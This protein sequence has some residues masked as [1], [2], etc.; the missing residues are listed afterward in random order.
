MDTIL[1]QS[2]DKDI[3]EW[4]RSAMRTSP[5]SRDA[6][7]EELSKRVGR[8]ISAE[9]LHKWC[10][11]AEK[12]R[13]LPADCIP[14][15]SEILGDDSL[16]RLLLTPHMAECLRLGEWL[17]SSRWVIERLD[18]ETP[19]ECSQKGIKKACKLGRSADRAANRP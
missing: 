7:A 11:E 2:T 18:A 12:Q 3:R 13:R 19:G 16:Q 6:I 5:R 10:S 14:A 4:L 17:L 9:S 8:A 15:L 1:V